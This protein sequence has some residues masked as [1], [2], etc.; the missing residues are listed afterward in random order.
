M[1]NSI[2]NTAAYVDSEKT[3]Q[4]PACVKSY[5]FYQLVWLLQKLS[6]ISP[7]EEWERDSRLVFSAN[8][9]LGFSTSD[10]HGIKWDSNERI[11][12]YTNFMGLSGACSPLP[13]FII[14]QLVNENSPGT[15]QP[16]LD[17]FNNRLLS[18]LYRIWRKYRY[19]IRFEQDAGD[20]VSEHMFAIVGL[21]NAR[22]RG[23]TPINWCKMLSYAGTLAGRSRSPQFVAGIIAHCFDL[24]DVQIWQ[25]VK[26]KVTIPPEQCVALG[27]RNALLGESLLLGES[28]R[29]CSGKFTICISKLSRERFVQFLPTGDLYEPLRKLVEFILRDQLAYDLE[30]ALDDTSS[31][32][33]QLASSGGSML[34]WTSFLGRSPGEQK[35]LIQV[36]Q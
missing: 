31:Y 7:E 13:G 18:L 16:F 24:T 32:Q 15:K 17:F 25:W 9:S 23:E 27:C 2:R 8:P 12:L 20:P 34:G 36:R 30:L 11:L 10:V 22:L 4:L 26:R 19:Y 35:V 21:G 28:I 29:D 5:N 6:S 14:E 1:G 3:T 33:L